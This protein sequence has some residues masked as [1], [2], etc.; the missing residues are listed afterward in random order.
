MLGLQLASSGKCRK[1]SRT[2]GRARTSSRRSR[3]ACPQAGHW[4]SENST[5][6]TRRVGAALHVRVAGPIAS[7]AGRDRELACTAR[8]TSGRAA[9]TSATDVGR[10]RARGP[11]PTSR[12]RRRAS[13]P[14]ARGR[15]GRR[16]ARASGR[17]LGGW[18]RRASGSTVTNQATIDDV[19]RRGRAGR[20]V[21]A[22][23]D[24]DAGQH[25][26]RSR[27]CPTTSADEQRDRRARP[28]WR[29][30]APGSAQQ[31]AQRED[32]RCAHA[33]T[34]TPRNVPYR[35]AEHDVAVDDAAEVAEA[36]VAGRRRELLRARAA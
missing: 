19:E 34:G 33:A 9:C 14:A 23:C 6:V 11:P 29:P 4:K 3:K 35:L 7:A 28:S 10:R 15:V 13:E 12:P 32:A 27:G 24:D 16:P 18:K 26:A 17:A 2:S 30:I 8:R 5:I 1:T 36:G 20:A 21:R 22:R 31:R 25:Q